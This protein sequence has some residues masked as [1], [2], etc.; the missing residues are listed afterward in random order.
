M[1][2]PEIRKE[3][4]ERHHQLFNDCGVFWAFS[5]EQFTE[6][7]T[8]LEE[9]DK[10]VSIGAGG[11]LPKSNIEKLKQGMKE[12]DLWEKEQ[13]K[14]QKRIKEHIIYELNNHECFYTCS[15]EDVLWLP[16]SKE[17]IQEVY[18]EEKKRLYKT[19]KIK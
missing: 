4:Q 19:E 6:N 2:Y 8:P 12:I 17:L 10:Y 13:I 11:F 3:A 1:K 16:Y 14:G 15:I 9:G 7:K 5:N 18:S